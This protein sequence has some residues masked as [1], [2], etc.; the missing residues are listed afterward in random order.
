MT[1]Q[2]G[3]GV[4]PGPGNGRYSAPGVGGAENISV[5]MPLSPLTRFTE[6]NTRPQPDRGVCRHSAETLRCRYRP[7]GGKS[8]RFGTGWSCMVVQ[9]R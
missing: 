6:T 8:V 5:C 2:V 7:V 4:M 3:Q 1:V 9:A